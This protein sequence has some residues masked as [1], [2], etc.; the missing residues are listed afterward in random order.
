MP[1]GI[2]RRDALKLALGGGVAT[3]LQACSLHS[4]PG[5]SE[6]VPRF[7]TMSASSCDLTAIGAA[8]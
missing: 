3:M 7:A 8:I 4:H 2:N 6:A 5:N 1:R